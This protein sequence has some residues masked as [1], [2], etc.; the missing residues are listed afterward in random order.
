MTGR[1]W[2]S[3]HVTHVHTHRSGENLPRRNTGSVS[4]LNP[5]EMECVVQKGDVTL[6]TSAMSYSHSAGPLV[7]DSCLAQ[8]GSVKL[9]RTSNSEL[10]DLGG[11]GKQVSGHTGELPLK[12]LLPTTQEISLLGQAASFLSLLFKVG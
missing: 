10:E 6:V 9:K 7:L 12:N 2:A 4:L 1:P 5:F 3:L 11:Q 8:E